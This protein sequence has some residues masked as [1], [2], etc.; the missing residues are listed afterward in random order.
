ME[1]RVVLKNGVHGDV[2]TGHV[3]TVVM[4]VFAV[5]FPCK[6]PRPKSRNMYGP[7]TKCSD[8]ALEGSKDSHFLC[9]H[10]LKLCW[11]SGL[12]NEFCQ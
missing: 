2:L 5:L 12:D 8:G 9:L 3:D 11:C 10:F 4:A 6:V 1:G 7:K